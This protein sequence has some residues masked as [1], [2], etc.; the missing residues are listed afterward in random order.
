MRRKALADLLAHY[1]DACGWNGEGAAASANASERQ[2]LQGLL[3]VVERLRETLVPVE[4]SPKFEADLKARLVAAWSEQRLNELAEQE[5][6]QEFYRRAAIV[7]SFLS[8][9]AVAAFI[10]RG[11]MRGANARAA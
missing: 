11:R 6:R 3:P 2:E 8:L 9:A 5:E 1:V 10:V 4:P 7:G